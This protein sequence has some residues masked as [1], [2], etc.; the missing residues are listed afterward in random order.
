[1]SRLGATAQ[2]LASSALIAGN[3]FRFSWPC[4]VG[5]ST[6]RTAALPGRSIPDHRR[7]SSGRAKGVILLLEGTHVHI[8]LPVI[9]LEN[10]AMGQIIHVSS[11]DRR[12]FYTAQVARRRIAAGAA[13]KITAGARLLIAPLCAAIALAPAMGQQAPAKK[14][15]PTSPAE[16]RSDYIARL[17]EVDVAAPQ[18]TLGSLWSPGGDLNDLSNDYKARKVNDTLVIVASVQTTAS[19]EGDVTT[20]RQASTSTGITGLR[21]ED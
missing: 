12:Q 18:H 16:L 21:R 10:G 20:S 13:V 1:M 6:V 9:C 17:Q 2:W 8:T 19:Q 15:K 5:A 7:T 3:A 14:K 11:P 4:R